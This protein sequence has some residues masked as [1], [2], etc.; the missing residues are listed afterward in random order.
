MEERKEIE[1]D[2]HYKIGN[3]DIRII[4]PKITREE[5]EKRK[6]E[7]TKTITSIAQEIVNKM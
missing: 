4:F 3:T 7:I 6:E 5:N 1:Y 2:R